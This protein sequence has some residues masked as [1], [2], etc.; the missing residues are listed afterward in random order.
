MTARA[1]HGDASLPIP[2]EAV[3]SSHRDDEADELFNKLGYAGGIGED[4]EP[5]EQE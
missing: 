1:A 2:L 4:E 5:E 3:V